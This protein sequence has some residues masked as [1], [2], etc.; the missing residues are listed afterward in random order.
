MGKK[1][2][3]C[4]R[5][6]KKDYIE[7]DRDSLEFLYAVYFGSYEDELQAAE[8][9][10]YR[11]MNRTLR[12]HGLQQEKRD[13]LRKQAMSIIQSQIGDLWQEKVADQKTYDL[14]HE[15]LSQ[16][17][18][19]LYEDSNVKFTVGQAQKWINMTMKY[20]YVFGKPEMKD[21]S[22]VCHVPLDNYIFEI[23]ST[24]LN[25]DKPKI[26]WS[27][28][29]DYSNQYMQYQYFLRE[30]LVDD[31][32]FKWEFRAWLYTARRSSR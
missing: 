10:A 26:P 19:A 5:L 6:M 16:G 13:A 27:R 20:L 9:R 7:I 29:D 12:F 3:E 2:K 32:P 22:R 25:I 30:K 4:Y 31:I 11:D 28:W 15:N 8:N 21:L 17:I 1:W 18:I 14:W 24:S 23:A